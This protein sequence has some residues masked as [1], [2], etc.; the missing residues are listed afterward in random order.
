MR[1]DIITKRKELADHQD[2]AVI[3]RGEN[4]FRWPMEY[5][6][7]QELGVVYCTLYQPNYLGSKPIMICLSPCY[8]TQVFTYS[9][10]DHWIPEHHDDLGRLSKDISSTPFQ[11]L[12]ETLPMIAFMA[13][14][15]TWLVSIRR[16]RSRPGHLL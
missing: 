5:K 6:V 11:I 3:I 12:C 2:V 4:F 14:C 16:D 9:I 15:A 13:P 1:F 8:R 7:V 10:E